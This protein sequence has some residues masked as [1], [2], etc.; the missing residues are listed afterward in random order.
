MSSR[1]ARVATRPIVATSALCL[2]AVGCGDRDLSNSSLETALYKSL[3]NPTLLTSV[4]CS[5]ADGTRHGAA[6]T[7]DQGVRSY[8]QGVLRVG[9]WRNLVDRDNS[10]DSMT[11]AIA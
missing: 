6:S 9:V 7:V 3:A 10:T 8:E 2:T 5:D 4:Y 11:V 1:H